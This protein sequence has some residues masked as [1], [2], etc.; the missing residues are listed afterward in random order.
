MMQNADP[1]IQTGQLN[2]QV[3]AMAALISNP[4]SNSNQQNSNYNPHIPHLHHTVHSHSNMPH[5][6][7]IGYSNH[8][9]NNRTQLI[10]TTGSTSPIPGVVVTSGGNQANSSNIIN[11]QHSMNQSRQSPNANQSP[12]SGFHQNI[13]SG[14]QL[15]LPDQ[16]NTGTNVMTWQM[17]NQNSNN[18]NN[19]SNNNN[20]QLSHLNQASINQNVSRLNQL[21]NGGQSLYLIEGG[22]NSGRIFLQQPEP[23]H[24]HNHQQHHHDNV[25]NTQLQENN[26]EPNTNSNSNKHNSSVSPQTSSLRNAWSPLH[27]NV[28]QNRLTNN[29]SINQQGSAINSVNV[30]PQMQLGNNGKLL[31]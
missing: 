21:H 13:I 22:P 4:N 25:S 5:Q 30:D 16:V 2:N 29:G 1:S 31:S 9:A 26:N 14:H 27:A 28:Q 3:A 10:I 11:N 19:I 17:N 18:S 6:S 15:V 24:L 12:S 20:E 8:H 23:V 7:Q